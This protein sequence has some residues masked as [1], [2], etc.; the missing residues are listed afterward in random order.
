MGGNSDADFVIRLLRHACLH[1][2]SLIWLL[3]I[4]FLVSNKFPLSYSTA[5]VM[6]VR[7][8]T[9]DTVYAMKILKKSELRRRKQ[10]F[11]YFN[12]KCCCVWAIDVVYRWN[13]SIH[14]FEGFSYRTNASF[15][16]Y[17]SFPPS[18]HRW[19]ARR[20]SAPFWPMSATLSL[21]VCTTPSSPRRSSTWSWTSCR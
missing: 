9:T 8:R 4:Y 18:Y 2:V 1:A 16:P 6:Q 19:S 20:Q 3:L 12:L 11:W 21:C 5:Q 13:Q 14:L 7:H 10:V 15:P 17:N